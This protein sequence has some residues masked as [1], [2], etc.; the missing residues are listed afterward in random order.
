MV[1]PKTTRFAIFGDGGE[2]KVS[3]LSKP[4]K[5]WDEFME[6]TSRRRG[7]PLG[8]IL[9]F[10]IPAGILAVVVVYLRILGG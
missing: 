1:W 8:K 10:L 5:D 6:K 9:W 3:V 2:V 4:Q 7:S